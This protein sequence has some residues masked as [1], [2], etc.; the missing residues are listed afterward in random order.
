MYHLKDGETDEQRQERENANAARAVRRQ[1][2]LATAALGA[3]QQPCQQSLN[4]GQVNDNTAHQA[5]AAPTV[6]Q[7]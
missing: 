5:P 7:Q 1:Q 3:G 4:T 6:P 2:E